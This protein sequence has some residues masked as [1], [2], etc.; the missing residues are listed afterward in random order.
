MAREAKI[1]KVKQD[2]CGSPRGSPLGA[3]RLTGGGK[4]AK[5]H[6]RKEHGADHLGGGVW[7]AVDDC[8]E[9]LIRF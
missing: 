3:R 6:G 8:C 1:A 2:R 9:D 4:Q 7:A 5:G